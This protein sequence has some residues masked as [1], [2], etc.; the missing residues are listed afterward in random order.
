[1]TR[2]MRV[3]R[4]RCTAK[5]R[6]LPPGLLF[7]SSLA[8]PS[9][10]AA[11]SV[12]D[13]G[14]RLAVANVLPGHSTLQAAVDAASDGDVLLLADGTYTG[15]VSGATCATPLDESGCAVRIEKS[16]T[17]RALNEGQAIIDGSG[18]KDGYTVVIEWGSGDLPPSAVL[19]GIG[20][21]GG[22]RKG[23]YV[24]F[25]SVT[26]LRCR[27]FENG[28]N[29]TDSEI[30]MGL[31][32]M[33]YTCLIDSCEFHNNFGVGVRIRKAGF[34]GSPDYSFVDS[35]V[36]HNEDSGVW[37]F[38][39]E[40]VDFL[41][42]RVHSN[43][44]TTGGGMLLFGD[45]EN[46]KVYFRNG[47]LYNNS[48][49]QSGGAVQVDDGALFLSFANFSNNNA[50]VGRNVMVDGGDVGYEFPL[51]PGHFLPNG[52]TCIVNRQP[53]DEWDDDCRSTRDECATT[54]GDSPT[55]SLAD[56]TTATCKSPKVMQPCEYPTF[57]EYLG[58][59]IYFLNQGGYEDALPNVCAPGS[60]GS[61]AFEGQRSGL[62]AGLCPA[63]MY[64][65]MAPTLEPLACPKNHF[66]PEGSSSPT[67]CPG[68]PPSS[69]PL[70]I[71][72]F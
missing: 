47:S 4:E 15:S 65:P 53:C 54:N 51:E 18:V 44:A 5:A 14:R 41:R 55:V 57:S 56:G 61:A 40:Q 66:C 49:R 6:R 11:I 16:I 52:A 50:P 38:A 42:T 13:A 62:C 31:D 30:G 46:K 10:L 36:H 19:E 37:V 34:G 17:I 12:S 69:H 28:F 71:A 22:G 43:V 58:D 3:G 63:G 24:K 26:L 21:K 29:T 33:G 39:S 72:Q 64:C 45:A 59:A 67:P 23:V 48:A 68:A 70:L 2:V 35:E 8:M 27:F 7:L 32:L 1:M 60:V 20:V 9:L 25:A